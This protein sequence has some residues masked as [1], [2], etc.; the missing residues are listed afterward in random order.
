VVPSPVSDS[1]PQPAKLTAARSTTPR[2]HLARSAGARRISRAA[3]LLQLPQAL[4]P[5]HADVSTILADR[6]RLS[7]PAFQNP[8]SSEVTGDN[9]RGQSNPLS[10]IGTFCG[11]ST[12][13]PADIGA[14]AET[15]HARV[16]ATSF[17]SAAIN[18]SD[19]S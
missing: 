8:L 9:Y 4:G 12:V 14:G 11:S 17:F 6:C 1:G 19:E 10:L 5:R 15:L 13:G 7:W 3:L 2:L 16:A 18:D